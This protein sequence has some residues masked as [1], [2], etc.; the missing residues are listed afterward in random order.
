ME[1]L[2][3]DEKIIVSRGIFRKDFGDCIDFYAF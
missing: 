1:S 3:S 2:G